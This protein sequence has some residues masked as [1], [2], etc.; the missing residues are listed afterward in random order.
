MGKGFLAADSLLGEDL[1]DLIQQACTRWHLNV[2]LDAIVNDS[3]ATLLSKAYSNPPTPYALILGTGVNIAAHLPIS[4]ISPGKLGARPPST[5]HVIVNT[6]LGMFGKGILPMTRWDIQL[7]A[8]H[9]LPDFQPLELLVGGRYLG[10]IARLVLLDAIRSANAFDGIVPLSL[11]E[12][13][14]MDT[15]FLATIQKYAISQFL[16]P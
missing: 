3:S 14:S 8:E 15:E 13:Y 6:E 7:N 10:E 16:S 5:T 9:A 4:T 2:R 11:Q 1:G 12:P